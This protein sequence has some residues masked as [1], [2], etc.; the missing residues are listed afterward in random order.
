MKNILFIL[1]CLVMAVHANPLSASANVEKVE[2][3]LHYN[4]TQTLN[5]RLEEIRRMDIEKM[6]PAEKNNLRIELRSIKKKHISAGPVLVI[7]AGALI[8][9]VILLILLL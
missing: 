3:P 5:K 2:S 9:I 4:E 6:S 1:I 7:S 8:L